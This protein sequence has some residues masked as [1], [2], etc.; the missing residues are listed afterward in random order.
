MEETLLKQVRGTLPLT[1]LRVCGKHF[2]TA[3]DQLSHSGMLLSIIRDCLNMSMITCAVSASLGA[4]QFA[5]VAPDD[6]AELGQTLFQRPGPSK[7]KEKPQE[8]KWNLPEN[9]F[10]QPGYTSKHHSWRNCHE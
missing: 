9:W 1:S 2:E 4:Y 7:F 10:L 3:V 6:C 8:R 5:L